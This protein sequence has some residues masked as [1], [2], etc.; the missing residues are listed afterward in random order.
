MT[1][2]RCLCTVIYAYALKCW[3]ELKEHFISS[4]ET[5][6]LHTEAVFQ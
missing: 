2:F 5:L 3:L 6:G 1:F 4:A